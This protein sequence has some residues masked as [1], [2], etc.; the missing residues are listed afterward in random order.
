MDTLKWAGTVAGALIALGTVARWAVLR[1]VRGARWVGAVIE[2]PETVDRL[3][4]SV[5]T[6]RRSVDRLSVAVESRS[7]LEHMP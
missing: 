5:D 6:L 7:E 2:L 4:E 3:G 1:L